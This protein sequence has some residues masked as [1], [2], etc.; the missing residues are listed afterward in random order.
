MHAAFERIRGADAIRLQR[1]S[2]L[3]VDERP[4]VAGSEIVM[5]SRIVSAGEPAGVRYLF[6]VDLLALIDLA[7]AYAQVPDLFAAYNAATRRCRSPISSPP[8]RPPS[9]EVISKPWRLTPDSM[10]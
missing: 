3:R 1:A 2:G 4:A 9:P 6:D 7:P 10:A 8:L 5:E